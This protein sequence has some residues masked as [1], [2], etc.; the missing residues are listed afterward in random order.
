LLNCAVPMRPSEGKWRILVVDDDHDLVDLLALS[1]RYRGMEPLTAHNAGTALHLFK[2]KHPDLVMLDILDNL[3]RPSGLDVLKS[4]RQ[5]SQ[6]PIILLTALDS[7]EDKVRGLRLGADDYLTKPFSHKELI[8]R[9]NAVMRRCGSTGVAPKAPVTRLTVGPLMLDVADHSVTKSD[10]P[11]RLT[12]TEFR[13]LRLLMI[14]AG[15]VVSY[16]RL[17]SE[18]WG[19]QDPGEADIAIARVAVHRLRQ[20][21]EDDPKHPTLLHTINSVGVLLKPG[22]P[23]TTP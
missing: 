10:Q 19:Y 2:E 15:T 13:V 4:L 1:F 16:S 22:P 9:I 3:G 21:L 7:E 23:T 11:L 8:E 17:L 20:K 12:P 14:E 18:V 6:V 5:H